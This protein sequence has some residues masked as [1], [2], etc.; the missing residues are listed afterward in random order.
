[1]GR[2]EP[3]PDA[4]ALWDIALPPPSGR[5]AGISMAG[6]RG[7][8]GRLVDIE[9]VPYPAMTVF[10]DFG[11]ATI[12]D[13]GADRPIRDG[14]VTG[15]SSVGVRGRGNVV[16]CLQ[17]RLSPVVAHAVLEGATGLGG[18]TVALTELWGREAGRLAERLHEARSWDDRFALAG[19]AVARRFDTGRR[20]EPEIAFAWRRLVATRG[21]VRIERLA[22]ETGWS[23][24]RLWSRFR[25]QLGTT[26]KQAANL[27]R[28]DHAAH[29]LAGG[30]S[31]AR[32]AAEAGY[33]DQSHMHREVAAFAGATPAA[34][35]AAPWLA[36]DDIAW[37]VA[38]RA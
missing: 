35:A 28:F 13:S 18:D 12:L 19:A 24:K 38:G 15:L 20:V 37:P 3:V 21:Q 1:M 31:A 16:D 32:V 33:S 10:L 36:V 17:I 6:F 9:V 11:D 30:L 8:T 7:R 29:A 5:R 23:R 2:F 14:I 25:A 22:A 27:V 26:P 4:A 34:V